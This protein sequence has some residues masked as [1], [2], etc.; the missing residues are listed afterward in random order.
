MAT[1]WTWGG[2][3]MSETEQGK[4]EQ[5]DELELAPE[6]VE[7]LDAE[8]DDVRGGRADEPTVSRLGAGMDC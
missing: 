1:R 5:D 7:D 3:K 8:G 6:T 4:P 2:H